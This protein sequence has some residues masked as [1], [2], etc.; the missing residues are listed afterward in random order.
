MSLGSRKKYFAE[1]HRS[2]VDAAP[3][4]SEKGIVIVEEGGVVVGKDH[5]S[6]PQPC[7]MK[8]LLTASLSSLHEHEHEREDGDDVQERKQIPTSTTTS[9]YGSTSRGPL[10]STSTFTY[11]VSSTR[12]M[13]QSQITDNS[14]YQVKKGTTL[15]PTRGLGEQIDQTSTHYHHHHHHSSDF[16]KFAT[17]RGRSGKESSGFAIGAPLS[18]SRAAAG[19]MQ[20]T[21]HTTAAGETLRPRSDTSSDLLVLSAGTGTTARLPGDS[22]LTSVDLNNGKDISANGGGTSTESAGDRD[23]GK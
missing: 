3:I 17:A 11:P 14:T 7:E 2:K 12:R 10:P 21:R 5:A 13:Q 23:K 1:T 16:D 4:I 18:H 22:T 20:S 19:F 8:K 6:A 15:S 9:L